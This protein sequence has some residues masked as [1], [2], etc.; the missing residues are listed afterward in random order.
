MPSPNTRAHRAV[1]P[2]AFTEHV[3]A[4]LLH[5][6]RGLTERRH[7]TGERYAAT[8]GE[9]PCA[10]RPYF[11]RPTSEQHACNNAPTRRN[12][13][14]TRIKWEASAGS[15]FRGDPGSAEEGGHLH[16]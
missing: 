8:D 14:A 10:S 7:G 16:G 12:K 11:P 9:K 1:S 2:H 4:R 3:S 13:T 5:Q 15:V 6:C